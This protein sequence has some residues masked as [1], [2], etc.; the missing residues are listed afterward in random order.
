MT[1]PWRKSTIGWSSVTHGRRDARRRCALPAQQEIFAPHRPQGRPE[2]AQKS[3]SRKANRARPQGRK[4]A[5]VSGL[6][7]M[8]ATN[9]TA[10]IPKTSTASAIGS[11]SSQTRMIFT[12][13]P[14]VSDD[15]DSTTCRQSRSLRLLT[16]YPHDAFQHI[17]GRSTWRGPFCF[18]HRFDG[19]N[20]AKIGL[21]YRPPRSRDVPSI[22]YE[23]PKF[24][25][26]PKIRLLSGGECFLATSIVWREHAW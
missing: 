14:I 4:G 11:C 7:I 18:N 19:I 13:R 23:R 16:N 22:W 20:T 26:I 3:R 8:N 12:Y 9:S 24:Q 15:G 17:G 25:V 2:F 10:A 1:T 5:V 6:Q 21:N